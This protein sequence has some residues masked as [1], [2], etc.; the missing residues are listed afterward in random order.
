VEV[1]SRGGVGAEGEEE[2]VVPRGG[3]R[4]EEEVVGGEQG[5]RDGEEVEEPALPRAP[6][7]GG[8]RRRGT[9]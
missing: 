5:G 8:S 2:R 9:E 7:V 4:R 6:A 1:G 3:G